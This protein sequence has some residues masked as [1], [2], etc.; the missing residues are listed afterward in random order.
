MVKTTDDVLDINPLERMEKLE[1]ISQEKRETISS[2]RKEL[3]DFERTK[4]IE[5]DELDNR[6]RREL[7]ELDNRKKK[8]LDALDKKRKELA[9]LESKK[10][11][12]IEDTQQL[13]ER[14]FQDLMRHKRILLQE[15]EEKNKKSPN[16]GMSLEEVASTAPKM[17]HSIVPNMNYGKFFENMQ[18]PQRLYDVTNN[19]FY[20][21]LTELRNRAA[22]GQITPEEEMFVARLR[23]Q[24][25]Q[26]NSNDTYVEKDQNQY[27]KRSISVIDQIDK[28]QRM[29]MD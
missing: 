13:I 28:Y 4:K 17:E 12:E 6:K 9:E 1:E 26:F 8:E 29:K 19:N 2:K 23:N 3:A 25:E 20:N 18:A 7:E 5:I 14:S 21:G 15:D 22:S 27:I 11:K 10:I 24:F 16:E